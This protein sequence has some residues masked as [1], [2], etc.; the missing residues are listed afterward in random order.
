MRYCYAHRRFT[1]YP[2]SLDTWDLSTGAYTDEFL[3]R[4]RA[5]GL[6]TRLKSALT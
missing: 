1:L 4:V 3:G 5:I 6:S 2:N